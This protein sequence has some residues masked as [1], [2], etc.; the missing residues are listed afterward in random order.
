MLQVTYI[1]YNSNSHTSV[2]AIAYALGHINLTYASL[3]WFMRFPGVCIL[4][5]CIIDATVP[6]TRPLDK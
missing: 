4:L 5:Q 6:S 3:G 1:D 2:K